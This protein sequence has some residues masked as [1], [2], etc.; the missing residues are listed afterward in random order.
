MAPQSRMQSEEARR[1]S[2][3]CV[4]APTST[5]ALYMTARA[6]GAASATATATV[7]VTDH[8][9]ASPGTVRVRPCVC[10]HFSSLASHLS[11]LVP[12][13]THA[14]PRPRRSGCAIFYLAICLSHCPIADASSP[15]SSS[16]SRCSSSSSSAPTSI[17][18][19]SRSRSPISPHTYVRTLA[20]TRPL[21][22]SISSI[23]SHASQARVSRV[24]AVELALLRRCHAPHPHTYGEDSQALSGSG[25]PFSSL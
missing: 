1:V 2:A 24:R 3:F 25:L 17:R 10:V 8:G 19:R 13:H 12:A 20:R 9:D 4:Q 18:R 15:S 23:Q 16:G 11:S 14:L 5:L 21:F 7:T 6:P 22:P